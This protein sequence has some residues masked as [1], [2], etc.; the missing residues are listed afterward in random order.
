MSRVQPSRFARER[1]VP[2]GRPMFRAISRRPMPDAKAVF[3]WSQISFVILRR[4]TF[5][6]IISL[7]RSCV[8]K[9][10]AARNGNVAFIDWLGLF[11][12]P[13]PSIKSRNK[14]RSFPVRECGVKKMLEH[15]P[16][17]LGECL[18]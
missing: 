8:T 3:T 18:W 7:K 4:I 15:L 14:T 2:G 6:T 10:L 16:L 12:L 13:E 1:T 17:T 11:L 5:F 9:L